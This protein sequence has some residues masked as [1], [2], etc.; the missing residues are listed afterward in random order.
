TATD[1]G[2]AFRLRLS[3]GE[4]RITAD[5]PAFATFEEHVSLSNA[6]DAEC[7]RTLNV[8]MAL[9]SRA[10]TGTGGA[11]GGGGVGGAGGG[12]GRRGGV[13]SSGR[14]GLEGIEPAGPG[15]LVE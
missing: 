10:Q 1:I 11:G 9:R 7:A 14:A 6:S 15:G 2:G 8:Q 12:G 5:L 3:P 13:G 4:Y